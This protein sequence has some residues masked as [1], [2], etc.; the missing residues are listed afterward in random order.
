[1]LLN[2]LLMSTCTEPEEY[3]PDLSLDE[4]REQYRQVDSLNSLV[5]QNELDI[6]GVDRYV[7]LGKDI[8]NDE[9]IVRKGEKRL[10]GCKMYPLMFGLFYDN[11]DSSHCTKVGGIKVIDHEGFAGTPRFV[12]CAPDTCS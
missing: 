1:M 2:L 9:V 8:R 10:L 6:S 11:C 5:F 3:L 4:I 12:G 7:V